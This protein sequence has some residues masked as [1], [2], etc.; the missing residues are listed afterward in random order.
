MLDLQTAKRRQFNNLFI[1]I[2]TSFAFNWYWI[3]FFFLCADFAYLLI[4]SLDFF[5]QFLSSLV[6]PKETFS[7]AFERIFVIF[8]S[9][10]QTVLSLVSDLLF[11]YVSRILMHWITQWQNLNGNMRL[12]FFCGREMRVSLFSLKANL[13]INL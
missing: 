8:W 5:R 4:L 13:L 2:S 7:F 10:P 3:A 12:A 9:S 1:S 11:R 6:F